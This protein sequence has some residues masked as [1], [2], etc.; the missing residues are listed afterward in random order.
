MTANDQDHLSLNAPFGARCF[1][2][3]KGTSHMTE[4][5]ISLNAP[6]GARCFMTQD[7]QVH[8]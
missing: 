4:R 7:G 3:Q 2:T 5:S 8:G 6:F 1:M